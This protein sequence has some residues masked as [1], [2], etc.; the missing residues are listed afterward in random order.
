[1]MYACVTI[2]C[3]SCSHLGME[4]MA[5]KRLKFEYAQQSV[6]MRSRSANDPHVVI[7]TEEATLLFLPLFQ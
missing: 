4:L 5:A 7:L 2:I 1:M 3:K 6:K